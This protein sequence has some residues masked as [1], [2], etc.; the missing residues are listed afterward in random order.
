MP[1]NILSATQ[2]E[3]GGIVMKYCLECF[4]SILIL[5]RFLCSWKGVE[6]S[7]NKEGSCYIDCNGINSTDSTLL[8]LPGPAGQ[9]TSPK[10]N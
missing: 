3:V 4:I 9:P 2:A 7:L 10:Q 5:N 1:H 8:C 6:H